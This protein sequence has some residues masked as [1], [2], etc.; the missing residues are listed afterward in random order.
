MRANEPSFSLY[1]GRTEY[2]IIFPLWVQQNTHRA[3]GALHRQRDPQSRTAH[4]RTHNRPEPACKHIRHA[5]TLVHT[6]M[7]ALAA[8]STD[9][10]RH[11]RNHARG[12][13]VQRHSWFGWAS[14]R[15]RSVPADPPGAAQC[16]AAGAGIRDSWRVAI[17]GESTRVHDRAVPPQCDALCKATKPTRCMPALG[18]PTGLACARSHTQ[19]C[20][21]S[22]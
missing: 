20:P 18:R 13:F 19:R 16:R 15:L 1:I 17:Q 2:T 14:L 10:A 4:E 8:V 22:A 5:R 3:C 12:R 9:T 21:R 6:Q 11:A 7:R